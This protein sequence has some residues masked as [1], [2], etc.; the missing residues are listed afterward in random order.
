MSTSRYADW[1]ADLDASRDLSDLDKQSYGFVLGWFE[2]WR[3]RK[4][5]RAERPT[6]VAFWKEQVMVKPRKDWQRERWAEAGA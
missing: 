5:L 1:R 3:L 6:A 4:G 2:S